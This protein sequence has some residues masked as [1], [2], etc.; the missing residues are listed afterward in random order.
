VRLAEAPPPVPYASAPDAGLESV[1]PSKPEPTAHEL[2]ARAREITDQARA[3][4]RTISA[5]DAVAQARREL[6]T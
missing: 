2:A 1:K 6:T 4:G 3:A 5:T